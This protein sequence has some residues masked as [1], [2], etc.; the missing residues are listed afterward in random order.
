MLQGHLSGVTYSDYAG[1]LSPQSTLELLTRKE[2]AVS[3]MSDLRQ[4]IYCLLFGQTLIF[5]QKGRPEANRAPR[6]GGAD[7]LSKFCLSGAEKT[8]NPFN[9]LKSKVI[10]MDA[11]G[12]RS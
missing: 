3:L 5:G 6:F 4:Y 1:D 10:V 12:I 2:N 9:C 7:N 8:K 11:D